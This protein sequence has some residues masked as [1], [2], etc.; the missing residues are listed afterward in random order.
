MDDDTVI[1]R[2][3]HRFSLYPEMIS[4]KII[5]LSQIQQTSAF[6]D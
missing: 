2:E 6:E 5:K 1:K 3:K 4:R